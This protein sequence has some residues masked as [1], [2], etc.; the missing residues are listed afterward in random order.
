MARQRPCSS[1]TLAAAIAALFSCAP[2]LAHTDDDREFE[3][4]D[5]LAAG[6]GEASGERL[7]VIGTSWF[8]GTVRLVSGVR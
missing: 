8:T 2:S 5:Q 6:G 4:A 3:E 1:A 7:K